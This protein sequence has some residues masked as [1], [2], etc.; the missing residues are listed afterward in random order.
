MRGYVPQPRGCD[1][2]P[3]SGPSVARDPLSV[4][5]LT[6]GDLHRGT[7][8]GFTHHEVDRTGLTSIGKNQIKHGI[9][10]ILFLFGRDLRNAFALQRLQL[11]IHNRT[12][13]NSFWSTTAEIDVFPVRLFLRRSLSSNV[14]ESRRRAGE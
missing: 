9:E 12:D 4:Q 8:V 11:A 14:H 13:Q 1:F 10:R 3:A 6:N 5:K 7:H 2:E